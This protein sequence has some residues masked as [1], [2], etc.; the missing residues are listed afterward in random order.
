MF[1]RDFI[2]ANSVHVKFTDKGMTVKYERSWS[3]KYIRSKKPRFFIQVPCDK[4]V[5]EL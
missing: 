5:S 1:P 3:Q 4:S 2:V